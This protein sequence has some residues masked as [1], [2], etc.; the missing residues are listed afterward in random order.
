MNDL[1]LVAKASHCLRALGIVAKEQGSARCGMR[2]NSPNFQIAFFK[3]S[4]TVLLLRALMHE[5]AR[6]LRVAPD[7]SW[8]GSLNDSPVPQLI[9]IYNYCNKLILTLKEAMLKRQ[10]LSHALFNR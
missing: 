8:S 3:I 9:K 6:V 5:F 4:F 10:K 1:G 2:Q 7:Y